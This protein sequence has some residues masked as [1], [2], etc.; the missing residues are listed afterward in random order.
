M[1]SEVRFAFGANWRRFLMG[2]NDGRVAEAE[3]SLK[4]R[5]QR[6][7]LDGQ[8][9]LDV[10]SGSGLFSLAA[11]RL[12]A[13]VYSFDYDAQSVEC[14]QI[15][16]QKFFPNDR[17]W[18]IEQGSILDS[19]YATKLG[20]FDVVYSWGVLHHT[21]DMWQALSNAA[22]LVRRDGVLFIALYNDQGWLSKYWARVK[23]LYHRNAFSRVLVTLV[24]LPYLYF[25]RWIARAFR[26][27]GDIERGMSLWYDM[28]DWLG[29]YPF[30]VAAPSQV[31][32]FCRQLGFEVFD[33][34]TCGHKSGCNEFVLVKAQ[35][36]DVEHDTS[37]RG[38]VSVGRQ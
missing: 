8:T 4:H 15:L 16:K 29:G 18:H 23:R 25:G 13:T 20:R 35:D 9:F 36:I 37:A 7:R 31:L 34:R 21:G 27:R 22:D 11:R 5:L 26:S 32:E 6:Q 38:Q 17:R 1:T 19:S 30:E 28:H 24:H 14:T 10:G 12:G 33:V 2:L 3:E